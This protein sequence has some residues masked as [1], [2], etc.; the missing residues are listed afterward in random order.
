MPLRYSRHYYDLYKLAR[1]SVRATA[2]ARISLLEDV[3]GFKQRFYPSAWARYDLA[4]PG[5]FKLLPNSDSRI[6]DLNHDYQDMN[7][8]FFGQPPDFGLI[9]DELRGLESL[10]NFDA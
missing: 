6:T 10:I 9:L 8:M 7:V 3:V 5:S 1:S 4:V 2:L